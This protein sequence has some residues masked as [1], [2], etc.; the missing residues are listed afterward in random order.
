MV[1]LSDRVV[2]VLADDPPTALSGVDAG[3]AVAE[4]A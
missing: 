1:Q 2:D 3:T 4:P